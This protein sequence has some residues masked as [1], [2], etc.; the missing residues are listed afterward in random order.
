MSIAPKAENKLCSPSKMSFASDKDHDIF[1]YTFFPKSEDEE[2]QDVVTKPRPKCRLPKIV[3]NKKNFV[4]KEAIEQIHRDNRKRS[5]SRRKLL[6]SLRG[7]RVLSEEA[8]N[9]NSHFEED[10][11]RLEKE[12]EERICQYYKNT[13]K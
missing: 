8:R 3:I 1:R 5:E 12:K 9:T 2:K 10:N 11:P 4:F 7:T 6:K 13:K